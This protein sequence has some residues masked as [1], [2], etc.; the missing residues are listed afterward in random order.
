VLK[1]PANSARRGRELFD[2]TRPFVEQSTARSWWYVGSTFALMVVALGSAAF[3]PWWPLRLALSL[4]GSLVMV[5]AFITFHDYMHGA[6]LRESRLAVW[7]FQFYGWFGLTPARSWNRSHNYH[8]RHVGQISTEGVG[9]FPL[10]TARMWRQASRGQ[11]AQYRATRHPLIILFGYVTVFFFSV[12]LEPLLRNPRHHWDSAISL[13]VH[14]G[15]AA[16]LWWL[17]GFDAAFFGLLLPMA[18]SSVLGGF[19]F[20]AQHSFES[21]KIMA[22][23]SWDFYE[24]A[25][26]SSSFLRVS[27]LTHWFTGNIGY[28]HV[29]HLNVRIPFYRLPEAM[30]AIPE[31]QSPR[32]TSLKL[33]DI[34]GCFR[35]SLWC[36]DRQR[37]V[38]YREA[39]AAA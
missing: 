28:H 15:I 22:P 2:A 16:G 1:G 34:V 39:D 21:M 20:F 3:L 4:L 12:T 7:L 29:H 33:S 10:I 37:M 31:L 24:A 38:S 9:S 13:L 32:S 8:H 17:G 26:E 18:I 27:K 11:R 14:G 6:I 5:R 36:E 25:V 30:A 19:L 35:A 23:D